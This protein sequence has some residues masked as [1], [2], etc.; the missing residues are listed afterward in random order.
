MFLVGSHLS[1]IFTSINGLKFQALV[2]ISKWVLDMNYNLDFFVVLIFN[3]R[4]VTKSIFLHLETSTKENC[5]STVKT[6]SI[7]KIQ[8]QDQ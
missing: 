6:I 2:K 5:Y 7:W 3:S 4:N 8:C 1:L